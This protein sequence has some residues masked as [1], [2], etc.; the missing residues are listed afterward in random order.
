MALMK[1]TF[2]FSEYQEGNNELNNES[3]QDGNK[4]WT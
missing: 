2:S 4:W 3:D 1:Y